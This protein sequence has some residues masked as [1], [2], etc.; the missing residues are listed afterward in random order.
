MKVYRQQEV[1]R[2][3]NQLNLPPAVDADLQMPGDECCESLS[4]HEEDSDGEAD[5]ADRQPN[6][7]HNDNEQEQQ[8]APPI[9]PQPALPQNP[10][11]PQQAAGQARAEKLR[12]EAERLFGGELPAKRLRRDPGNKN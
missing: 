7:I 1:D 10:E 3:G 6:Q 9:E 4:T 12:A 5:Q 2:Q 8:P 11:R